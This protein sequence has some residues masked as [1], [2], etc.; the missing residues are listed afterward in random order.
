MKNLLETKNVYSPI[1]SGLSLHIHFQVEWVFRL[2]DMNKDGV[3]DMD[4]IVTIM[5]AAKPNQARFDLLKIF[6]GMDKNNDGVLSYD[7]F[8]DESM[9]NPIFL[10]LSGLDDSKNLE[11][12][13]RK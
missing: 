1:I 13:T 11:P 7:E 4:E 10:K 12:N 9:N 5:R 6:K 3:I 8:H 2:Y